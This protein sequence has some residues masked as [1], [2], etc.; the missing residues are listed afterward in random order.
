MRCEIS[1]LSLQRRNIA[2][3]TFLSQNSS[4]ALQPLSCIKEQLWSESS[5]TRDRPASSWSGFSALYD[6]GITLD[7]AGTRPGRQRLNLLF[8]LLAP[9]QRRPP[10]LRA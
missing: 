5:G 2:I 6:I 1:L 9:A 4:C 10:R 7:A 3:A 8:S